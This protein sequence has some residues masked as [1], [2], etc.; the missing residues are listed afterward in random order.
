MKNNYKLY[1]KHR[2]KKS[3]IMML[4]IIV[5]ILLMTA[6]VGYSIWSAQLN[7]GTKVALGELKEFQ[8]IPST[9]GGNDYI[10]STMPPGEGVPLGQT[11][12]DNKLT[13]SY[14]MVRQN[15]NYQ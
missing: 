2:G 5:F 13:I 1:K 3:T 7:I 15:R 6:S 11:L 4:F 14:M 9:P 12:H 8:L 10:A